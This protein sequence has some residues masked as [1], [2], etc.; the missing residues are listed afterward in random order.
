MFL[1]PS[2]GG[3]C[4]DVTGVVPIGTALA[5]ESGRN[6]FNHGFEICNPG[7]PFFHRRVRATETNSSMC[8]VA[9]LNC[10]GSASAF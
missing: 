10:F 3:H 1:R 8:K 9:S 2:V 5:P 4:R 7:R 6:R